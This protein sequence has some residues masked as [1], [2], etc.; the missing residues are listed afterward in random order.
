MVLAYT[1]PLKSLLLEEEALKILENGLIINKVTL[2]PKYIN[3]DNYIPINQCFRCFS[4]NNFIKDCKAEVK[5]CSV[6]SLPVSPTH[7]YRNCPSSN[8]PKC[9]NCKEQHISIYQDCLKRK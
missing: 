3:R 2:T 9:I 7:N 1:G 5:S 6:C 8:D 4:F